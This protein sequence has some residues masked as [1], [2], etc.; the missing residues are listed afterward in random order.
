[1]RWSEIVGRC[2]RHSRPCTNARTGSNAGF[3]RRSRPYWILCRLPFLALLVV[4]R[5]QQT[6]AQGDR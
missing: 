5:M 3:G 1:M 4:R 6:L 2:G